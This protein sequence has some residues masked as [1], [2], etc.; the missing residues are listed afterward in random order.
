MKPTGVEPLAKVTPPSCIASVLDF[1]AI[2]TIPW[3]GAV[4]WSGWFSAPAVR[5]TTNA[6]VHGPWENAG[7]DTWASSSASL[8]LDF[9]ISQGKQTRPPAG[10]GG[11]GGIDASFQYPCP[12]HSARHLS[13]PAPLPSWMLG[14]FTAPGRLAS[15]RQ[16]GH[17]ASP[18]CPGLSERRLVQL[19]EGPICWEGHGSSWLSNQGEEM[20]ELKP[21]RRGQGAGDVAS[22]AWGLIIRQSTPRWSVRSLSTLKHPLTLTLMPCKF[23]FSIQASQLRKRPQATSGKHP[24]KSLALKEAA[25]LAPASEKCCQAGKTEK[26]DPRAHSHNS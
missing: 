24:M 10:G 16:S 12:P 26:Q 25:G 9:R 17:G 5:K 4:V 1:S 7:L 2:V 18:T 22:L 23:E 6:P 15:Q 11:G 8:G 20:Q 3:R 21:R 14:L 13:P 19:R